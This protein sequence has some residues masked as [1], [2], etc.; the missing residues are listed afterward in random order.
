[1]IVDKHNAS[2]MVMELGEQFAKV[3]NPEFVFPS[4]ELYALAPKQEQGVAILKAVVMDMDGTTTTTEEICLHALEYMVRKMGD[5]MDKT[6][7]EGLDKVVDYP[8]VIGNSTTKHVEYL[9]GQYGDTFKKEAIVTAF[10]DAVVWTLVCGKDQ[11]RKQEVEQNLLKLGIGQMA[12][13]QALLQLVS[14]EE[15]SREDANVY[16]VSTYAGKLED[17]SDDM[18]VAM[19]ID[20]YYQ[21]YHELLEMIRLNQGDEVQKEVFGHVEKG[22]HLI[23]PMPGVGVLLLMMKGWLGEEIK[24]LLPELIET[25][26]KKRG[27]SFSDTD[28]NYTTNRLIE[29]SCQFEQQ[30]LKVGLVT[31]SIF[32][33]ADIVIKEVFAVL[34]EWIME[35]AVSEKR[36]QFIAEQLFDYRN[37]YDSFVTASDS[38]EIRLKPHRDLYSIALHQLGIHPNDFDKVAGF[39]D[40]QSGTVAMRAAGIGLSI[41]VPFAQTAG[42]DLSAAT[43]I[44]KGGVPEVLLEEQL[45]I[46][47]EVL[48]S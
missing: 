5:R 21:R 39:E 47:N 14:Q 4:Y 29:L 13:D 35:S 12:K 38:N 15:Y 18:L 8:N 22:Q 2:A 27:V 32:Y 28:I 11:K 9:L 40:S 37:V 3:K 46:R 48:Q 16:F 36:K 10:L 19:G 26:N 42:H 7:W 41:A 20:I 17:F 33:E 6:L 25:Y 30:P 31:S 45:F 1:M 24:N 23:E 44:C 34:R 43:F